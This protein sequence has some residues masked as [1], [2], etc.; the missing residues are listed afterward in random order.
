MRPP[1]REGAVDAIAPARSTPHRHPRALPAQR[2]PR[3]RARERVVW[4][5]DRLARRHWRQGVP[6]VL[7]RCVARRVV[8]RVP[9]LHSPLRVWWAYGPVRY[10]VT[11]RPAAN[12][13]IVTDSASQWECHRPRHHKPL[14]HTPSSSVRQAPSTT[15][16]GTPGMARARFLAAAVRGLEWAPGP[17]VPPRGLAS[18]CRTNTLRRFRQFSF[19]L[20]RAEFSR[21][22]EDEGSAQVGRTHPVVRSAHHPSPYPHPAPAPWLPRRRPRRRPRAARDRHSRPRRRSCALR[23]R[24][25]T[26]TR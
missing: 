1:R 20:P 10:G 16:H 17:S 13:I 19:V 5:H 7:V 3:V 22:F 9:L 4:L 25:A 21:P 24:R 26:S 12:A 11:C 15:G 14:R 8:E 18:S 2:H 6:A 23:R